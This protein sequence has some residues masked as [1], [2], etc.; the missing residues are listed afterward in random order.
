ML[1]R[2]RTS[3]EHRVVPQMRM[4]NSVLYL[5]KLEYLLIIETVAIENGTNKS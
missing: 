5:G 2:K 1:K 3:V 4:K